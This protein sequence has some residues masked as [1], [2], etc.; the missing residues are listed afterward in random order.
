MKNSTGMMVGIVVVIL[1]IIGAVVYHKNYSDDRLPPATTSQSQTG[2]VY[3]GVTDASADIKNVND[4]DMSIRK[5]EIYSAATGWVAISSDPK[6]YS[7]LALK[8]NGS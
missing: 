3:V 1:I 6:M 2:N 8:S 7:L 4:I 5:V